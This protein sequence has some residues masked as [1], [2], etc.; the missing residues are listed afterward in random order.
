MYAVGGIEVVGFSII[1]L[2]WYM[3][4]IWTL[5]TLTVEHDFQLSG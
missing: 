1:L 4:G 2:L 5:F 3:L